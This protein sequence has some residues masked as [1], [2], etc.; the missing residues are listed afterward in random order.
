MIVIYFCIIV[1]AYNKVYNIMRTG[2]LKYIHIVCASS[3]F[4]WNFCFIY[5]NYASS[6]YN[7][8]LI[9]MLVPIHAKWPYTNKN[10]HTGMGPNNSMVIIFCHST[11]IFNYWDPY[12]YGYGI[13]PVWAWNLENPYTNKD[14]AHTAFKNWKS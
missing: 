4:S 1:E 9:H 6:K 13:I 2:T 12:R 10:H 11:S 8:L 3:F 14:R 5:R 7:Q